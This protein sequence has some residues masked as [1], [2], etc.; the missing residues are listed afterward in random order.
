MLSYLTTGFQDHVRIREKFGYKVNDAMWSFFQQLGVIDQQ[1]APG[2]HFGDPSWVY[3]QYCRR[4]N[5][6]RSDQEILAFAAARIAEVRARGVFIAEGHGATP[7]QLKPALAQHIRR[8]Y[9]D[10]KVAIWKELDSDFVA[11]IPGA[12]P[13]RTRSVDRSDYILHPLS[14]EQLSEDAAQSLA[15]LRQSDDTA[16]TR[17]VISDGL[18]ALALMDGN[19]LAELLE[20]LRSELQAAGF[21]VAPSNLV[22]HAGRVRAGYRIGESLFGG[23]D[24]PFSLLHIIGERPGSG[25]HTLSV[26]MTRAEGKAWGEPGTVDHDITRVVSGIAATALAPRTGAI[27]AVKILGQM[28]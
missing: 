10:A 19:Q 14:G 7:S 11:G 17:I 9:E 2:A 5:D 24:G 27:E 21:R 12:L 25:H 8:I 13:L 1:G 20:T 23:R 15:A 22:L 6:A 28:G 4:N 16:D 3:L 26:Y 18:N